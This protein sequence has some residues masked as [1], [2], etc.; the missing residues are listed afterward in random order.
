MEEAILKTISEDAAE[1]Q[2]LKQ[3]GAIKLDR[4]KLPARLNVDETKTDRRNFFRA[5]IRETN[6]PTFKD[7]SESELDNIVNIPNPE[8]ENSTHVIRAPVIFGSKSLENKDIELLRSFR[9][10]A[11]DA[12]SVEVSLNFLNTFHQN[13]GSIFSE[14]ALIDALHTI[15]PSRALNSYHLMR[16]QKA[17][18]QQLYDELIEEY[19]ELKSRGEVL[20]SLH[21]SFESSKTALEIIREVSQLLD[22]AQH[23]FAGLNEIAIY[24]LKRYI[25][26]NLGS[27][28]LATVESFFLQSRVKTFR[29][30]A[31]I[32]VNNFQKELNKKPQK[33]HNVLGEDMTNKREEVNSIITRELQENMLQMNIAIGELRGQIN[34]INDKKCHGCQGTGH[35][36]KNCPKKPKQTWNTTS[37]SYCNQKCVVHPNSSHTNFNCRA[38]EIPCNAGQNH[39]SHHKGHCR[40]QYS[41]S[42]LQTTQ[43]HQPN[44][45]SSSLEDRLLRNEQQMEQVHKMLQTIID[46]K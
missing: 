43:Q 8:I 5:M 7:I 11:R 21:Q 27:H 26:N 2:K 13:Q 29:E 30:L 9:K 24:E 45:A 4:E 44:G 19:G 28:I 40:R 10:D 20:T 36:I 25:K 32:L 34:N 14:S 39:E 16:L 22:T 3:R 6:I 38:Q 31:K 37:N 1:I 42:T 17:D 23:D 15:L 33:L 12:V 46:N 41:A 35:F 18:L